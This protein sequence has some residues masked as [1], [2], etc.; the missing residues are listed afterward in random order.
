MES[1]SNRI[2]RL[3]QAW[4]PPIEGQSTAVRSARWRFL[5]CLLPASL[6]ILTGCATDGKDQSFTARMET[7]SGNLTRSISPVVASFSAAAAPYA[8]SLAAS[9][10]DAAQRTKKYIADRESL[11]N[12]RDSVAL[13]DGSVLSVL[14]NAGVSIGSAQ[15]DRA[16][17]GDAQ[18]ALRPGTD[19]GNWRWPVDAGIIT[20]PYGARWGKQH[21]G[22]DIAGAIGEPIIAM[23]D[24]EV[25]YS[26]NKMRGYGNVI[27]IKH[28]DD[29]TTL[30][31]HNDKLISKVGDHVQKGTVVAYLGNTGRS[32]GPH[33]HFEIRQGRNAL[34]PTEV[35]P[36]TSLPVAYAGIESDTQFARALGMHHALQHDHAQC[37]PLDIDEALQEALYGPVASPAV[38]P[39]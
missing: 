18:P 28:A 17:A 23:A 24:G 13:S 22:M 39:I 15:A 38:A 5:H 3:H 4:N 20:S 16:D 19:T 7:I 11:K 32:T 35:L 21:R 9:M 37:E 2:R 36:T 12:N 31:A 14:K 27:V 29:M 26:D 34:N 6:L 10:G 1:A 30:Y 33:T 8:N 25:V